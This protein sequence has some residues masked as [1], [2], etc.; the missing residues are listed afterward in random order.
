MLVMTLRYMVNNR[1]KINASCKDYSRHALNEQIFTYIFV[2]SLLISLIF[3]I[4]LGSSSP[5]YL[6]AIFLVVYEVTTKKR[7][8]FFSII[9]LH[10]ILSA[11]EFINQPSCYSLN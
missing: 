5:F 8:P 3:Y 9:N 2:F 10:V 4:F 1:Q 7:S 6:D 11:E